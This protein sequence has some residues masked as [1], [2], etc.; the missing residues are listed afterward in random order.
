[1]EEFRFEIL[2]RR[3]VSRRGRLSV[4]EQVFGEQ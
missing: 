2:T 4:S 1:M 3:N